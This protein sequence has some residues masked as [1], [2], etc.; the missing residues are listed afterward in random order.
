VLVLGIATLVAVIGTAA[1]LAGRVNVRTTAGANDAVEADSLA[2]SAIEQA[3]TLVNSDPA[4]RTRY[5]SGVDNGPYALG[6][7]TVTWKLVDEYD[8][9]LANDNVQPARLYGTGS[10]GRARRVYSV[11]LQPTGAGMEVLKKAVH[12]TGPFTVR[13]G[14]VT[15]AASGGPISTDSVFGSQGTIKAD[16]EAKTISGSTAAIQGTISTPA[17]VR[18]MPS[19]GLF[20]LY[21][22]RATEIPWANVSAGMSGVLSAGNNR[23]GALNARGIY[24]V[25]VPAGAQLKID[26]ARAQATLLLT[27][28]AGAQVM[29]GPSVLWS[30]PRPDLPS[31][32]ARGPD[33]RLSVDSSGAGVSE[34]A[35]G[36]SLNPPATPYEGVSDNDLADTYPAQINGIVHAVGSGSVIELGPSL[37]MNGLVLTD[38]SVVVGDSLLNLLVNASI[39]ANPTLFAQPPDGYSVGDQVAPVEGTWERRPSP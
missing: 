29:V 5:T 39:T 11:L 22:P 25:R 3:L 19:P 38:G 37:R 8:G 30:P 23:Y 36:V 21:L 14:T 26:N 32:V 31:I 20:D 7:G 24:H 9:N 33:V 2:S 28:E 17:A 35:A 13:V 1:V 34:L 15:I 27:C 6:R 4:W 16:V 12:S 10:A 18:Q